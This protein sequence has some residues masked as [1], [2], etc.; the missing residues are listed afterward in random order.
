VPELPEVETVARGL[1]RCL[2]GERVER[3]HVLRADSIAHPGPRAFAGA[4]AGRRF[5]GV[6]RR[7]KY[8]LFH[9]DGGAGMGAHLRMSGRLLYVKKGSR[10]GEHLRVRISLEGGHELRFED[11]RV[12]GRL[13]YVEPGERFEDVISGLNALGV[14]PLPDLTAAHLARGFAG[15]TQAVKAALLDQSV[16]AGLGNIYADEALFLSGLH[17]ERS[18]AGLRADELETLAVRIK[19]VLAQAIELGGTTLRDYTNADG[20]NGN[21]QHES[22][23]YGRTG[24]PCRVCGRSVERVRLAGR[25]AH[26]CASCQPVSARGRGGKPGKRTRARTGGAN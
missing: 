12:F 2:T 20:V 3:V 10:Q 5:E 21:Y 13:W 25:S 1:R 19:E 8:L 24:S 6:D 16:V 18:I 22:W 9:L 17:P 4:L 23:V 7:G 11:M 14:E 26:F 15:R